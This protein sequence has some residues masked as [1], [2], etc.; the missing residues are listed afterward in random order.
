MFHFVS[1]LNNKRPHVGSTPAVPAAPGSLS[2]TRISLT[3]FSLEVEGYSSEALDGIDYFSVDLSYD[4]AFKEFVTG[5]INLAT[6]VIEEATFEGATAAFTAMPELADN[7]YIRVKAVNDAGQSGWTDWY[8]MPTGVARPGILT[9]GAGFWNGYV[10][11]FNDLHDFDP[12]DWLPLEDGSY[13]DLLLFG[14]FD[15]VW[16]MGPATGQAEIRNFGFGDFGKHI[17]I[18]A[19]PDNP[20]GVLIK[21]VNSDFGYFAIGC[22]TVGDCF[23]RDLQVQDCRM[24]PQVETRLSVYANLAAFPATGF[25]DHNYKAL[26][27]G[28][29]YIW[30]GFA[31]EAPGI[32]TGIPLN[33]QNAVFIN[34]SVNGVYF[35]GL[36]NGADLGSPIPTNTFLRNYTTNNTGRDGVQH[37][38]GWIDAD[39][40]HVTNYGTNLEDAHGH[41]F[42]LGG[43]SMGG[44]IKNFTIGGTG[45]YYGILNK[46]L[47]HLILENGIISAPV[48]AGIMWNNYHTTTEDIFSQGSQTMTLKNVKIGTPTTGGTYTL[49]C[50]RDPDKYEMEINIHSDTEFS[51]IHLNETVVESPP[52][53]F[54]GGIVRNDIP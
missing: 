19:H 4:P 37:R 18:V 47:G 52:G 30:N 25:P 43:N 8:K 9:D 12:G 23:F 40:V 48:Q 45:R 20:D 53:I 51:S 27:T 13:I 32:S 17:K 50:E 6:R 7:L 44:I 3:A 24:G 2:V 38:N 34:C 35:E 36:Y 10:D 14:K 28:N 26:D 1:A 16:F 41:G 54:D 15:T 31:Y 46:M 5:T 29:Y 11:D 39:G 21:N 49:D 22:R 33:Y 42:S